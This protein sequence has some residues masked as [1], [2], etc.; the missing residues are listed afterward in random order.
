MMIASSL[1]I[2]YYSVLLLV[3]SRLVIERMVFVELAALGCD[4]RK[5]VGQAGAKTDMIAPEL[6]Y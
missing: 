3:A 1:V 2:H 5:V 4:K 6:S